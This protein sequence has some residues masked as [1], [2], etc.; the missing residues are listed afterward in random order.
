LGWSKLLWHFEWEHQ[1]HAPPQKFEFLY[2]LERYF[3]YFR[4]R[5]EDKLQQEKA[6]FKSPNV[7]KSKKYLCKYCTHKYNY[8]KIGR[9][10]RFWSANY[11]VIK[12]MKLS[13]LPYLNFEVS[14]DCCNACKF[15]LKCAFNH[16]REYYIYWYTEELGIIIHTLYPFPPNFCP[17]FSFS[18]GQSFWPLGGRAR[19]SH[20]YCILQYLSLV[21]TLILLHYKHP[22]QS[23]WHLAIIS[24]NQLATT[25][26]LA[27]TVNSA[28]K[29]EV[30]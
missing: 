23:S 13:W 4:M 5:F 15:K 28:F 9:C 20:V 24:E 22:T 26:V 2:S 18:Q 14:H 25:N 6:I 12:R 16:H 17:D 11:I 21:I 30:R 29:F 1:K 7:V 3:T 10:L 19:P 27:K 8:S